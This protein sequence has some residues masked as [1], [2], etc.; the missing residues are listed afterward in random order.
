MKISGLMA[1]LISTGIIWLILMIISVITVSK[2]T[3]LDKSQRQKWMIL[4]AILPFLGLLIYIVA[5]FSKAKKLL[6]LGIAG[7]VLSVAATVFFVYNRK[8][9]DV[10]QKEGVKMTAQQLF[11]AFKTDENAANALY[12]DKAIELSGEIL[13]VNTNQD[14]QVVVDIKTNDP[15]VVINCTFKIDPGTLTEGQNITFKG[16][17]RGYIPDANVVINDGI[18]VK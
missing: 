9:E 7:A 4:V 2:R 18:L 8:H 11:D 6:W 3:D 14:G 15:F 10:S 12:L 1:G 17:C 13:A 16:F 5:N